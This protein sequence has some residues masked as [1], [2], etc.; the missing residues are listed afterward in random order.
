[1]A[2]MGRFDV[3]IAGA[4]PAGCRAAWRL[5]AAGV[6]VALVDGSHP[7]EKPC[8]GGVTGRALDLVREALGDNRVESV[9]IETAAF[10]HRGGAARMRISA[11]GEEALA[12]AV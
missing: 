12:M 1:M 8:G 5:A 3:A 4:G 2:S 6:R 9:A 10:D 7:R 11:P